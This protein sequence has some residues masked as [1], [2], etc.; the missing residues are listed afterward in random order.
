MHLIITLI[1]YLIITGVII[2][3]KPRMWVWSLT[4]LILLLLCYFFSITS[5]ATSIVFWAIYLAIVIPMHVK[6]LRLTL[7]TARLLVIYR[8]QTLTMSDT[9]REA[10]EA[11]DPWWEKQLFQGNP[12]WQAFQ[13]ISLSQLNDE[14]QAFV[15]N[16]TCHLANKL[17]CWKIDYVDH[18]LPQETLNEIRSQ[19]F[20]G[21]HIAKEHGGKNFSARTNSFIN[22]RISAQSAIAATI[23]MVCNSLGPGLE[24]AE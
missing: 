9:E 21:L 5:L 1:I 16:E 22:M 18:A 13:A 20:L 3:C 8:K 7:L 17:D 11:G 2:A 14:E 10:L 24:N 15:D 19:G 12:D 6:P 4:F 23:I